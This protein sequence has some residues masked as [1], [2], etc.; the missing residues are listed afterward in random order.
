MDGVIPE[1]D[2][3]RKVMDLL[4]KL[5]AKDSSTTQKF[6]KNSIIIH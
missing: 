1:L 3:I 6:K 5:G 4:I 2:L